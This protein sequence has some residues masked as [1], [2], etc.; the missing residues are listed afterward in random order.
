[1][2][3]SLEGLFKLVHMLK[4]ELHEQ[5]DQLD[6]GM[7]PMHIRTMKIIDKLKPCTAVDIANF[8]QRDKAQVTRLVN[9]LIESG[10]VVKQSNPND[11][12]SHFLKITESGQQII[13]KLANVDAKTAQVMMKNLSEEEVREFMRMSE[14]MANNLQKKTE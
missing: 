12:R 9:T 7:A 10:L 6:M 3:E 2:S 8:L 13:T 14:V 5:M 4:R 11:K 1:M